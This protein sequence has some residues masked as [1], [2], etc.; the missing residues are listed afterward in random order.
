[1]TSN[2][3]KTGNIGVT[4]ITVTGGGV[5][6]GTGG[7][8]GGTA[9]TMAVVIHVAIID[10]ITATVITTRAITLAQESAST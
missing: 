2:R 3:S 7:T 10:P 4:S 1:M 8:Q 5:V 9:A 6:T